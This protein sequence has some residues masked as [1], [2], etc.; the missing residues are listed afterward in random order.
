MIDSEFILQWLKSNGITILITIALA[1]VGLVLL[2]ISTRHLKRKVQSLDDEEGSMLDK[3]TATIT[4]VVWT[5]GA[6]LIVG[7][8]LLIVLEAFGVPIFPVLASVGFAGLA[9]GLGAQTLVKD[10]ISGLFVLIEDQYTIG[11]VVEIGGVAG[12]V[13]SITLRKTTVRDLYGTV[14]HIPN[15]EVRTVANKSR[16]W[17]RALV[18]V[19]ITYDA[20]VDK[21]IE[22]L[23]QIGAELQ[24][25]SP[26]AEAILEEPVVTGIEGLDDSAVRL[27]IMVK[28]APG[29]EWDTQRYLRRQIRLVFAEQGID[30]AFPTQTVQIVNVAG[31]QKMSNIAASR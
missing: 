1:I 2:R 28:T 13:E 30:I 21:A 20:D 29:V 5:T 6:V 12:T 26:L 14:H 17:S 23:R 16:G 15:G 19:G 11:D 9:F 24:E 10:M 8:A 31:E 7:T 27:R 3:R 25:A 4:R 18:E 22:T